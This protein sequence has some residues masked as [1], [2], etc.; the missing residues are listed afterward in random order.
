MCVCVRA[1]LKLCMYVCS[2]E[3]QRDVVLSLEDADIVDIFISMTCSPQ[4][5]WCSC[6]STLRTHYYW[7]TLDSAGFPKHKLLCCTCCLHAACCF[8]PIYDIYCT[9]CAFG[10]TEETGTITVL[11]FWHW[12]VTEVAVTVTSLVPSTTCCS[13]LPSR[14]SLRAFIS[15][16]SSPVQTLTHTYTQTQTSSA[17]ASTSV[18]RGK[19]AEDKNSSYMPPSSCLMDNMLAFPFKHK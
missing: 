18:L 13:S 15:E 6:L 12:F 16:Y 4:C 7:K 5:V 1:L 17:N 11:Q 14:L 9:F 19:R 10:T 3:S 8:Y 2:A